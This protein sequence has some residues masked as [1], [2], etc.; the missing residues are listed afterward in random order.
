MFIRFIGTVVI[1]W[2]ENVIVL[3]CYQGKQE[4]S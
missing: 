4:A 1:S 2:N 3:S